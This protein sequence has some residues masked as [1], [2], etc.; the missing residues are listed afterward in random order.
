M[1]IEVI[2]SFLEGFA[3]I[4]S[5]CIL[6]ILPLM[7]SAS[8]DGGKWRPFGIIVGFVFS[9]TAFAMLSRKIVSSLGINLELIKYGSLLLLFL[10]GLVL[11]SEKLS[12]IFNNKTSAFANLGNKLTTNSK[13][14]FLSGIIVGSCI[15]LV[16]TPCAGPI[17]ATVLVQIIRQESDFQALLLIFAFSIG[18]ALPMFIISLTGR[19]IMSKLNFLTNN[20][21]KLRKIFGI[22]IIISVCF[23]A[24]DGNARSYFAN[25]DGLKIVNSSGLKDGLEKPYPAAEIVGIETWLNSNPLTIE[26]LKGKVVLIDFWTYS[27]INCVN[28]LP[29][30]I[31]WDQDYRDK[32]LVIIGVHAPEF[33][34]E[35]NVQNVKNA[36]KKYGIKY[37][38]AL[39]NNLDTWTNFQNLYWPAHYL[40]DKEGKVVYTHFGEGNYDKTENNIRYLLGLN[41]NKNLTLETSNFN[42]NQTPETYLGFARAENFINPLELKEGVFKFNLPQF[43]PSDNWALYGKWK[44]ESQKITSK[45][46]GAKLQLNFIAKKVFLV[47]GSSSSKPIEISL[48]L[49][50]K[51]QGKMTILRHEI[52]QLVNQTTAK[53]GLL[54]ITSS[55]PDLEAYAFTFGS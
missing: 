48:K 25:K 42:R 44:I 19:K 15:G 9:F 1:N 26:S 22:L 32:G 41:N 6:P 35:K 31:K 12:T 11:L 2:L 18:A 50:G 39:D 13:D 24:F 27:C 8:I 38:V 21:A 23:I 43:L 54:E 29:Y 40:I 36:L 53:N 4:A 51:S 17:L 7:L 37:P 55:A 28:T 10:F 30:V 45:Q 46:V 33:E 5:P 16:W 14:G 34:F 3:L 52:Y 20:T 47:L 49:N